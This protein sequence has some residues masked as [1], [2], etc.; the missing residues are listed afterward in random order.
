MKRVGRF[1]SKLVS[2]V[3]LLTAMGLA[4]AAQAGQGTARVQTIRGGSAT[5]S[6]DGTNWKPL[7]IGMV[8]KP[9]NSII[10]DGSAT[11]DLFLK[12]NGPVVRVTKATR[13][14]LTNLTFEEG[15]EGEQVI[16]TQLNLI[17]GRILGAVKKLAAASKYEVKTPNQ[18]CAI[19][20]TKYDISANGRVVVI[21]GSVFISFTGANGQ[22]S[23]FL[24]QEGQKFDPTLNGGAGGVVPA[25]A[26]DKNPPEGIPT[27][28][29]VTPNPFPVVVITTPTEQPNTRDNPNLSGNDDDA[30]RKQDD[31][32]KKGISK[33]RP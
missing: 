3:A 32:T 1:L 6:D 13:L 4:V 31:D 15:A 25:T 16:D 7:T 24:V 33:V 18:T 9:G 2:G 19:R 21:E 23:S 26:E 30:K 14:D 5:Y 20:G 10:T 28:T 22:Q 8:L 12:Q 11:V 29:I 27:I 17:N